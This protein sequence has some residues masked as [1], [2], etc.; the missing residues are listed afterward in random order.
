MVCHQHVSVNPAPAFD[1]SVSKT[2]Q[3][4]AV[5]II[6]EKNLSAVVSTLNDVMGICWNCDSRRPCHTVSRVNKLRLER[7]ALFQYRQEKSSLTPILCLSGQRAINAPSGP[8][9]RKGRAR[10]PFSKPSNTEERGQLID[11]PAEGDLLNPL[12]GARHEHADAKITQ[13]DMAE[14][15]GGADANRDRSCQIR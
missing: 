6:G 3:E 15:R 8:V 1:L 2:F 14:S 9:T 13:V 12:A 7:I 10:S 11:E 4:K 5:I